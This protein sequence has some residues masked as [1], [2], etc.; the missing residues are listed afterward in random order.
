MRSVTLGDPWCGMTIFY[1][2]LP[3]YDD[4]KVI[5]VDVPE[6]LLPV[7]ASYGEIQDE[8]DIFETWNDHVEEVDVP[9]VVF[10]LKMK[11]SGK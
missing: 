9:N 2:D 8:E 10:V 11:P 4:T 6:G 7:C 5:Y 3:S 1:E